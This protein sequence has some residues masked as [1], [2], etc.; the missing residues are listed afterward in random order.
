[1]HG[2]QEKLGDLSWI[3]PS[4]ADKG[5]VKLSSDEQKEVFLAEV[6]ATLA[7]KKAE[8]EKIISSPDITV[9]QK[10]VWVNFL[11]SLDLVPLQADFPFEARIPASPVV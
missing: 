2:F 10:S 1:L 3:G 6:M 5:W 11:L 9:E 7:T 8:T 4:Y